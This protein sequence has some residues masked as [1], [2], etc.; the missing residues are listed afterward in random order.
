MGLPAD[1]LHR[2]GSAANR[3]DPRTDRP[4][5]PLFQWVP[6]RSLAPRHRERIREHLL[7]LNPS[8]RYLRFG[9]PASDVQIAH[10]VDTLDFQRD[11]IVGIFNRRLRL[12]GMAHLAFD[13]QVSGHPAT[14]EFGVS[15]AARARG[16]GY[17]SRLFERAVLDA[18][19]RGVNSL[20][21]YALSEN[22]AMLRIVRKAG[23]RIERD[24]GE[25]QGTVELPPVDLAARIEQIVEHQAA[26]IDY[27]WKR[28]SHRL[29]VLLDSI[30]SSPQ[31]ESQD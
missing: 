10:Y 5:E 20:V 3:H 15:V 4:P 18:R 16:K 17:G 28:G 22:T 25:A 29:H 27:G 8:D 2:P 9:Y 13:D 24:G 30:G 12:V 6:I 23:G 19:N 7:A 21:I 11:E 14:A 26:E 31:E 1:I